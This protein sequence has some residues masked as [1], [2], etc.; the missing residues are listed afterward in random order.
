MT[1]NRLVL[2]LLVMSL[3]PIAGA[4]TIV[5]NVTLDTTP[6]VGHGPFALDFQLVD[7][8]GTPIDLNDNTVSLQGFSFGAGGSASGGGTATVGASGSLATGITLT[9]SAFLNEYFESF[10]PGSLL[11]FQVSTTNVADPGGTPDLFTFAILD[12]HGD[13]LPTNGSSSE[14]LDVTLSGGASPVVAAFSSAAGSQFAL[15]APDVQ[16][17]ASSVPEPSLF[18]PVAAAALALVA[19]KRRQAV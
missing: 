1:N 19:L 15:G 3:A 2:C 10:T 11:S 8:S 5:Y 14:F 12:S 7:G 9:D 6:L 13:E 16:A 17:A 18:P 4:D